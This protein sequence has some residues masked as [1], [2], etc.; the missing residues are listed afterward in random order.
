MV[1][2]RGMVTIECDL[3]GK[4]RTTTTSTIVRHYHIV[5]NSCCH[6]DTNGMRCL[7]ITKKS[8]Y[9]KF[10]NRTLYTKRVYSTLHNT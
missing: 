8:E 3:F 5:L 6:I 2:D 7:H 9:Q 1:T 4:D 10:E